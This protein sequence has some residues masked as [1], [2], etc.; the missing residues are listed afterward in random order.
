MALIDLERHCALDADEAWRRL[1]DWPRHG[2]FVPFTRVGVDTPVG[3]GSTVLART[4][5]GP[6][7][8]DDPMEITVWRPPEEGRPGL[9]GLEKRGRLVLG[10]AEIEVR[11]DGPG[12]RVRWREEIRVRG[13]PRFCDPVLAAA[14]RRMFGRTVDGL[15][16]TRS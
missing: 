10:R 6:V 14:G 11:P 4:A 16:R 1:T 2:A 12:S 8:F 3:E 9:C 15:L 5:L 13:L 7:G